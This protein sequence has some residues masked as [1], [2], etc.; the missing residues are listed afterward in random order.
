MHVMTEVEPK[1]GAIYARN[2]FNTEFAESIGF[3]DDDTART[4]TAIA[5]NS[6]AATAPGAIRQRCAARA[7]RAEL[8]RRWIRALAQ[9][10]FDPR[11]SRNEAKSSWER[12]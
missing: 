7:C 2:P 8:A 6:S 12:E 9:V 3:F 5:L 1:F 10:T 4:V 11:P